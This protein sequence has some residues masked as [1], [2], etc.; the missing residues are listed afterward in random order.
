MLASPLARRPLRRTLR[1]AH[2][3]KHGGLAVG[4]LAL[5]ARYGVVRGPDRGAAGLDEAIHEG[6][7]RFRELLRVDLEEA[8]DGLY[9]RRL[10]LGFPLHR[11]ALRLPALLADHATIRRRRAAGAWRELPEDAD[12]DRLPP[13]YRRTFHWQTDGYLSARSAALYDVGVELLFLGAADAMRRRVIGPVVQEARRV[14][15]PLDILDVACGTGRTLGML[16][17]ALPDARLSGLDLSPAYVRHA[18]KAL[19][20]L[21]HLSLQVGA[22][23][24]L[25]WPDGHFDVVTTTWLFHELPRQVRRE[26]ARELIRVVRPGGRVVVLASAQL[27]ESPALEPAL[28]AFPKDFHEPFYE[29]F[30]SD[31]VER[32][33]EEAGLESVEVSAW[34]VSKRVVGRRGA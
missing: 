12:A 24:A 3:V 2:L 25:P 13:Y 23:E 6:R 32:I 20:D 16:H 33:L 19:V 4:S 21:P 18:R 28:R 27:S 29:D 15:R 9:P 26:V 31:P 8:C 34:H 5:H 17:A 7:R 10:A 14:G 22:A 1:A 30:L 11:Y